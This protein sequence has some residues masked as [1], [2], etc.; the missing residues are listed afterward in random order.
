MRGI[1]ENSPADRK[2]PLA[3]GVL[4]AAFF[5]AAVLDLPAARAAETLPGPVPAEVL[6]V[7]DGDTVAVKARIW[8]GQEVVTHVRIA[9]IDTPESN[10]PRCEDEREKA[11][12]ARAK[13][14]KALA[15]G[16]VTLTNV[17]FDKWGGR[18]LADIRTDSGESVKD[19]ML[20]S[21][22]ARPYDGGARLNW[23]AK[24]QANR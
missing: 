24:S 2:R 6:S 20:K 21:G 14:Q 11:A 8:L 16:R 23:C 5:A 7:I 9:G 1:N 3:R 18:V 22:H 13:L 19:I 4:V 10:R 17:R 15:S 12:A